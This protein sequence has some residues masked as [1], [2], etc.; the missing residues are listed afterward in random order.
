MCLS[1][2]FFSPNVHTMM[3]EEF[4]VVG[5]RRQRHE[6][7]HK[8]GHG[9]ASGTGATTIEG[10]FDQKRR[11]LAE[12][13]AE[14][15]AAPADPE[16]VR[17]VSAKLPQFRKNIADVSSEAVTAA[18]HALAD[19]GRSDVDLLCIGLGTPSSMHNAQFQLAM[20]KALLQ[21]LQQH[22]KSVTLT[23]H[24]PLLDATDR[25]II[26]QW[27][28]DAT[29]APT[30]VEAKIECPNPTVVF[31]P[32]CCS[33]LCC[34]LLCAN[35]SPSLANLVIIG[36]SFAGYELR[37]MMPKQKKKIVPMLQVLPYCR[38]LPLKELPSAAEAAFSDTSVH[39][40]PRDLLPGPGDKL[41]ATRPHFPPPDHE[42]ILAPK[43]ETAPTA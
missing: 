43:A 25:D 11:A 21:G 10:L 17:K 35:W 4:K 22:G 15:A 18:V 3:E 8:K 39:V 28:P 13:M 9:S 26:A 36:N 32:H 14:A 29:V 20:V 38:E 12:R 6:R 33:T 7:R 37:S 40:F 23:F 24:E 27:L 1:I 30:N 31:M 34:N 42:V 16:C 41:W 5:S 2:Y 19:S